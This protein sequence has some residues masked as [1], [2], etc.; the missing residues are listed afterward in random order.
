MLAN[1]PDWLR[2]IAMLVLPPEALRVAMVGPAGF[3]PTT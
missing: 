3:E 2:V 1:P